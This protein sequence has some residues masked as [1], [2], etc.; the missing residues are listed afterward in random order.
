MI[1]KH[2]R[3]PW[4]AL[5]SDVRVKVLD[6]VVSEIGHPS[7][8]EKMADDR[9]AG[10][11]TL[12]MVS[13]EWRD[14][15]E[16]I[17]FHSLSI[18]SSELDEFEKLMGGNNRGRLNVIRNLIFRV[19]VKAFRS[20]QCF[21]TEGR[22]ICVENSQIFT[23]A[24]MRLLRVLSCGENKGP[25][26]TLEIRAK[27]HLS[28]Q[29]MRH[30]HDKY[31]DLCCTPIGFQVLSCGGRA[32]ALPK[33]PIVKG[34]LIRPKYFRN[35]GAASIG[36]I[37]HESLTAV[38]WL[39]IERWQ[40]EDKKLEQHFYKKLHKTLFP[41]LPRAIERICFDI[42]NSDHDAKLW[43]PSHP[44]SQLGQ[45][46]ARLCHRLTDFCTARAAPDVLRY[47][48]ELGPKKE[49][50]LKRLSMRSPALHPDN[51]ET[52]R[53]QLLMEATLAV[54]VLPR[55]EVLEIWNMVKAEGYM[56]RYTCEG[57]RAKLTWRTVNSLPESKGYR[58]PARV[59]DEWASVAPLG[60]LSD[61]REE[62]HVFMK[63]KE[64]PDK[65]WESCLPLL[66]PQGFVHSY[67]TTAPTW[68]RPRA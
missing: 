20:N 49:S 5:P 43:A 51:I 15:F 1:Y 35:V 68:N 16:P 21:G 11:A 32:V 58:L 63:S 19:D 65:F 39:R 45:D 64:K 36:K 23:S 53:D 12:A 25:G 46:M 66:E 44:E 2:T 9:F 48:A 50:K 60:F 41:L 57:A 34:L 55:L 3:F 59:I 54:K 7:N 27:S 31:Y 38:E 26:L 62:N 17:S 13:R 52:D 28:Y 29:Q 4:G 14:F 18:T 56:F 10:V 40:Q 37:L 42:W 8:G 67:P 61:L 6:L 47:L 33:A 30:P 22:E 24:M